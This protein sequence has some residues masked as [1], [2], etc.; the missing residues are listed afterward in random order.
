MKDTEWKRLG[1]LLQA[2]R[3]QLDPARYRK[4]DP[5]VAYARDTYG[6]TRRTIIDIE[7]GGRTNFTADSIATIEEA[8]ELRPGAIQAVLA[9]AERLALQEDPPEPHTVREEGGV[10]TVQAPI[11]VDGEERQVLL[12]IDLSA[13][14]GLEGVEGDERERLIQ[15]AIG[16]A[17][18]AATQYLETQGRMRRASQDSQ[19]EDE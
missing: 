1:T 13:I 16:A 4:R 2:R 12:P 15:Q 5:W 8:Y 17:V 10:R 3:T 9:G 7:T 11:V 6:L 18:H 19:D 14:P